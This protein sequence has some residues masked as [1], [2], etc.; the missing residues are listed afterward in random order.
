MEWRSEAD[1]VFC[2]NTLWEIGGEEK[3]KAHDRF[4]CGE[5][6]VR[7]VAFLAG[8]DERFAILWLQ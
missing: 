6:F 3:K 2:S 1:A 7:V 4:F 8:E 5:R